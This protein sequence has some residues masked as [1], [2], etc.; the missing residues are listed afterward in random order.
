MLSVHTQIRW[1]AFTKNHPFFLTSSVQHKTTSK[2]T[3]G[4]DK[5]CLWNTAPQ[6]R[7]NLNQTLK[8]PHIYTHNI[9]MSFLLSLKFSIAT[10]FD[11]KVNLSQRKIKA[12]TCI[13]KKKSEDNIFLPDLYDF[14][15]LH[16]EFGR[17]G[18]LGSQKL[19]VVNLKLIWRLES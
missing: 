9:K 3:E 7:E 11:T 1:N 18:S 17:W 19:L 4:K 2:P 8:H 13:W 10:F 12:Y 14:L 6:Q 15:V 16:L 5:M